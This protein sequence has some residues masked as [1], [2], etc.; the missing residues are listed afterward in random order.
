MTTAWVRRPPPAR[1]GA[2]L[3][4]RS[5]AAGAPVPRSPAPDACATWEPEVPVDAVRTLSPLRRGAGDPTCRRTPDGALWRTA[6]TAD[7]PATYR[8]SGHPRCWTLE[9]WGPAASRVAAGLPALLGAAWDPARFVVRHAALAEPHRRLLAV[10]VPATG[11]VWEAL[12]PAV[13][14]Q[15]VTG[16][17][18]RESWRCLL[19]RHGH[20]APGPAPA[21]MRVCPPPSRWARIPSWEWHAAGV[22]P[23][24]TH[25]VLR[26]AHL[27]GDRVLAWDALD[28]HEVAR[29][30]RA[31]PG[32]GAWTVA[33]VTQRACG[34]R[35]RVSVGDYHVAAHVG[36]VL[37]G[38]PVDD[39]GMLALLEPYRGDRYRVQ[40]LVEGAAPRKP[41]FGPRFSPP[42]LRRC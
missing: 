11:L 37:A 3:R 15:K 1:P 33:E 5:P 12:V 22:D 31:L 39:D 28:C 16:M 41:R 25:T 9:A 4:E 32:V 8:L 21:G 27:L 26:A 20:P 17:E 14:E 23:R 38:R 19:L 42:D 18:A 10:R 30:L 29:K 6:C 7:G 24:R 35:D 2:R 40:R 36:W 13:L 34:D